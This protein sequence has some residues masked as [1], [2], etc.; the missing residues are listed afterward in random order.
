M[1]KE[2]VLILAAGVGHGH[3]R[4]GQALEKAFGADTRVE[5][6]EFVDC[7]DYT[8]E[9]FRDIYSR[10]YIEAV[11]KA[12][13]LW[14][15]AFERTDV[16]WEERQ[17]RHW[18]ERVNARA[19][20]KKIKNFAPSVCVC[21]HF[22]PAV[23]VSKLL[24][25]D[26]LCTHFSVV[27]TDY[28]VHATWL[29]ELFCRYFVPHGEGVEQMKA[30]G[31]PAERILVS[32]IPIDPVFAECKDRDALFDKFGLDRERAVVLVSAG[33]VGK[34]S[35]AEMVGLFG[36][37]KNDCTVVIICG[38]HE[39][40]KAE[41]E[42]IVK[43]HSGNPAFKIVGFTHEMD[44]WMTAAD[45]FIGKPGG[46]TTA[47]CLAKGLPMVIWDPIPGQEVYNSVYLLE[48]GAGV[49]PTSAA[50]LGFKV[51]GILAD[52]EK[53]SAMKQAAKRRSQNASSLWD[54]SM[55]RATNLVGARDWKSNCSASK[56][57]RIAFIST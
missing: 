52:K 46:L 14:G 24:L 1:G 11:K 39:K 40:L 54:S 17:F 55:K 35:A 47:E 26:K 12:P 28:Y 42:Q 53:L 8:N 49:A 23:I 38:R 20:V 13:T 44:E 5:E 16:P 31:F 57:T 25:K 15:W 48:N 34:M 18:F 33:S 2:R 29:V 32:G 36:G 4:A 43:S 10:Y 30:V 21:T 51:D 19:L 56:S 41:L 3:N 9:V 22:M 45:L 27:V 37:I 50:T 6:V 7:L